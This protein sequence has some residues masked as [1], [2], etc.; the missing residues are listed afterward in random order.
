MQDGAHTHMWRGPAHTHL[1]LTLELLLLL[2]GQGA[3]EHRGGVAEAV[4]DLVLIRVCVAGGGTPQFSIPIGSP[5]SP[6]QQ[7]SST[8]KLRGSSPTECRPKCCSPLPAQFVEGAG[9]C[10]H[11]GGGPADDRDTEHRG[12]L[13]AQHA[14]QLLVLLLQGEARW[15]WNQRPSRMPHGTLG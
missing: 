3:S 13:T 8:P 11:L 6:G 7:C 4:L 5:P 9:Q 15:G 10:H 1:A 14:A 12:D 2:E